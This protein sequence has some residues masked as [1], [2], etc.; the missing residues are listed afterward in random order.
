MSKNLLL[1][2]YVPHAGQLQLASDSTINHSSSIVEFEETAIDDFQILRTDCE[3]AD[4][5]RI[6]IQIEFSLVQNIDDSH[7]FYVNG[8]GGRKIIEVD[9]SGNVY[10]NETYDVK[11]SLK[12]AG[13]GQFALDVTYNSYHPSIS[14]GLSWNGFL[15]YQGRDGKLTIQSLILL[16]S[17]E[18]TAIPLTCPI[19]LVDIG[20]AEGIQDC[21]DF[22]IGKGGTVSATLFEP[23]VEE[24]AILRLR[25]PRVK[26]LEYGLS[27]R[28]QVVDLHVTQ[29]PGCSS[30]LR[31]DPEATKRYAIAPWF[32]I[33]KTIPIQVVRY[34]ALF[35]EKLV[36][37]PDFIKIDTQGYEYEILQGFGGLLDQ[38]L[39]IEL[40]AHFYQIYHGQ[41]LL[42][43]IVEYLDSYG[44]TLNMLRP[45]MN[46]DSDYVEVN[47]FFVRRNELIPSEKKQKLDAI[48]G[49][50]GLK[51][52]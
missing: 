3:D 32:K 34:D 44:L 27:N 36:P 47:A 16:R 6:R 52:N 38:V 33:I 39:A 22:Y 14:L 43:D 1:N 11:Y 7:Q 23:S 17:D 48:A 49:V 45:Q 15:Q 20:A 46:F 13:E 8:W 26:V 21:W 28:K 50:L 10:T 9:L 18:L 24:A 35:Q 37:A 2:L 31:P 4:R 41:K 51:V 29:H 19:E 40:E 25:H 5:K 12:T 42:Q 30:I